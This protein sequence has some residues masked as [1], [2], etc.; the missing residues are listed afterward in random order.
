MKKTLILFAILFFVSSQLFGQ[1]STANLSIEQKIKTNFTSQKI[2]K[3]FNSVKLESNS[4]QNSRLILGLLLGVNM[5]NAG[6]GASLGLSLGYV[7]KYGGYIK[8]RGN[9][10][11]TN[12]NILGE[13]KDETTL[14]NLTGGKSVGE[15]YLVAGGMLGFTNNFYSYAGLGYGSRSFLAETEADKY[16]KLT[17]YSTTGLVADLGI[18]YAF[19]NN[20]ALSLGVNALFGS[21]V[22]VITE[23]G[24]NFTF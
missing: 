22:Y 4:D 6:D 19:K 9:T 3:S 20:F 11:V 14:T 15:Y 23:F 2:T 12:N 24:F 10:G 8:F 13:L 21:N 16:Y 7:K 5:Y 18:M 17:D 1:M